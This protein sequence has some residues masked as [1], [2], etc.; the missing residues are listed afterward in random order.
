MKYNLIITVLLFSVFVSCGSNGEKTEEET[1]KFTNELINET[2]PYL[3][4]HAHNPV[5]WMPWGDAAFEKAKAEKKLVLVSIGYSSCHWCHVM[6]KE[7]FENEEVA[8]IMNKNFIC[9]KVDREERPDVDQVYMNAVE[10]MT[11]G[12][13][14]P[15][16][17]FTLPDGKPIQGGTYYQTE[18]WIELLNN[19]AYKYEKSPKEVE[20]FAE[21]L[22]KGI[23]QDE[24]VTVPKVGI[25][26]S[27]VT[28]D[29]LVNN[30]K[31]YLDP[32][33][34]GNLQ[35]IKF[36]LPNN[37]EFM[38]QYA[39][40]YKDSVL[41]NHVDLTL[42]KMA[43]GGIY[44]QIGGGFARYS[45]DARWKVPHFEKMLYDN[46]QLVSLYSHAYKRTKNPLY[47]QVVYQTL[48]WAQREMMTPTGAFYSALD[49][50]SEGEEGKFYVW[51]KEEL[52]KVLDPT[53]YKL[54]EEFYSVGIK[55]LWEENYIL[56]RGMDNATYAQS[57]GMDLKSLNQQMNT[58]NK[59]LLAARNNRVRPGLDDKS[60]TSWNAMMIVGLLDAYQVFGEPLFLKGAL[61]NAQWIEKTQLST[62]GKLLHTFKNGQAKINGFLEDYCFTI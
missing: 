52:Q 39:Y 57:K 7:S 16:N 33:E 19:L 34:G 31:P 51:T 17:C 10:L 35:E 12:G 41:M 11:G 29:S 60:L 22:T 32:V 4:Q 43:L 50:D 40:H 1:H 36:P 59:K 24:L 53:E 30:W 6:E 25:Q 20:R 8:A 5:N 27:Q 38:Q 37:L 28:L 18:Q 23:Q 13:G 42:N 49:A 58:I 54:A 61:M 21:N 26:F 9:I 48:G 3:L 15:L 55:G 47:K 44:D 2:S 56:L 45:T 46:A 62:E 14:W